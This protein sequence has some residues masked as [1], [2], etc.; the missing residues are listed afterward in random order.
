MINQ[1]AEWFNLPVTRRDLLKLAGFAGVLSLTGFPGCGSGQDAA[2]P[3]PISPETLMTLR[4]DAIR[5]LFA[6]TSQS[7][8]PR[9]LYVTVD[10]LRSD[11]LGCYGSP[12]GLTPNLD[13]TAEKGARIHCAVPS[14]FTGESLAS[15]MTSYPVYSHLYSFGY[16]GR[17]QFY[18]LYKQNLF[19]YHSP[20]PQLPEILK[21]FGI[22]T[23][24]FSTNIM[25]MSFNLVS[26]LNYNHI[27][28]DP[29]HKHSFEA[30]KRNCTEFIQNFC[31]WAS[32]KDRFFAWMHLSNT[33]DP[34]YNT[35]LGPKLP[36]EL[37][38]NSPDQSGSEEGLRRLQYYL[39]EVAYTDQCAAEL[40]TALKATGLDDTLVIFSSDHGESFHQEHGFKNHIGS[41]MGH[42][43]NVPL[44]LQHP[45]MANWS[46]PQ[47]QWR[48]A[49]DL[50]PTLLE[51][52]GIEPRIPLGALSLTTPRPP[53]D[54]LFSNLYFPRAGLRQDLTAIDPAG[55]WKLIL[56]DAALPSTFLQPFYR[57][58]ILTIREKVS[59]YFNGTDSHIQE[60][61]Q[62]ELRDSWNARV[63]KRLYNRPLAELQEDSVWDVL[64]FNQTSDPG[65]TK[66]L[67]HQHPAIA[68]NL[69]TRL[70]QWLQ[71][72]LAIRST[73]LQLAPPLMSAPTLTPAEEK[74][75]YDGVRALGYI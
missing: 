47:N 55:I 29:W 30:E 38:W 69:L 5:N 75:V 61:A 20:I 24:S 36:D 1:S 58:H 33:H 44:I 12:L 9:V 2:V 32:G 13:Q 67:V 73:V 21:A 74:V 10:A 68:Q 46:T 64:L 54:I 37:A 72:Q 11:V 53:S 28:K 42:E 3:S 48:S 19:G 25:V 16:P 71:N 8:F 18:S 52:F 59:D 41:T 49:M 39:S 34:Y 45:D 17:R 51:F 56:R 66:N 50:M 43:I 27:Q 23:A 4:Q 63:E 6:R 26:D 57:K 7:T 22:P 31:K 35:G 65:E 40:Q 70:D 62:E 14:S 15:I 60:R